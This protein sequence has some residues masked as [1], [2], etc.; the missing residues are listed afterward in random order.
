MTDEMETS[1]HAGAGPRRSGAMPGWPIALLTVLLVSLSHPDTVSAFDKRLGLGAGGG[2]SQ[3]FRSGATEPLSAY[4]GGATAQIWFGLTDTFGISITGGMAWFGDYI[5]V[6][7]TSTFDENDEPIT[8]YMNGPTISRLTVWDL[9]L[10]GIYAIDVSR[11]VPYFALGAVVARVAEKQ[12]AAEVV[13]LDVGLKI[14]LGFDYLLL[15]HMTIGAVVGMDTFFTG[16]SQYG[17]RFNFLVRFTAV[18]DLLELGRADDT[19]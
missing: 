7:P 3:L 17:S 9:A 5:P 19:E 1:D 18:W 12:D 13:D 15:E 10:Q 16:Q 14:D 2:Y 8:E 4:G 6:I 11:V